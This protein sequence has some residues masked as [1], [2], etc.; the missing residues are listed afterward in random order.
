[1]A[2]AAENLKQQAGMDIMYQGELERYLDRKDT[3]EQN[4]TKFYAR[5]FSKYRYK[6][7]QI[8]IKEHSEF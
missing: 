6:T 1:V 5:I 3:L 2:D 8:R 7:M 4:L